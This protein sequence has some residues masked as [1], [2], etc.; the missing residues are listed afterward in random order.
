MSNIIDLDIKI[1]ELRKLDTDEDIIVINFLEAIK[2]FEKLLLS[3]IDPVS[4]WMG[5]LDI[6]E[7]TKPLFLNR[8]YF[9]SSFGET[10]F[11]KEEERVIVVTSKLMKET[12]ELLDLSLTAQI[13]EYMEPKIKLYTD[14]IV[15]LVDEYQK[16]LKEVIRIQIMNNSEQSKKSF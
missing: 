16:A 12:E 4:K 14:K 15:I 5:T 10:D 9:A 1:K 13:N 11:T 7:R 8:Y 6:N 2:D 3:D